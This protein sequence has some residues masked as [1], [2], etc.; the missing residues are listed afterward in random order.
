MKNSCAILLLVLFMSACQQSDV[1]SKQVAAAVVE[2]EKPQIEP[3]QVDKKQAEETLEMPFDFSYQDLD[4]NEVKLSDY[5]GKWVVVNYWA[6]W[7]PPCRKEMPDFVKFKE[8]FADQVEI[9]GIDNEDAELDVIKAFVKEYKIN[10]PI[11]RADVYNPTEF[12]RENTMG[13]PTTL[14]FNPQGYQVTKRVGPVHYDDLL[15]FVGF[16]EEEAQP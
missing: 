14:V 7:C 11:V 15:E 1:D 13:L 6:T 4:N 16:E 12:D 8:K 5:R 10:Y 3:I 2:V 9:I